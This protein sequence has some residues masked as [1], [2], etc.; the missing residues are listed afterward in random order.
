MTDSQKYQGTMGEYP[1]LI[2]PY[3]LTSI[4]YVDHKAYRIKMQCASGDMIEGVALKEDFGFNF[5]SDEIGIAHMKGG[6]DMITLRK[7]IAAFHEAQEG[8]MSIEEKKAES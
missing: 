4:E 1:A 7:V 6:V 8:R 3:Y 5:D 2:E